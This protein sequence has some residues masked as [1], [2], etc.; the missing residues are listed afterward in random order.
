VPND[1]EGPRRRKAP[2]EWAPSGVE[3]PR[4]GRALAFLAGAALV[5][6]FVGLVVLGAGMS[7]SSWLP[8][9]LLM[10]PVVGLGLILFWAGWSELHQPGRHD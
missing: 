8:V 1:R 9:V 7:S 3:P 6:G 4:S 2:V 5:F 10:A